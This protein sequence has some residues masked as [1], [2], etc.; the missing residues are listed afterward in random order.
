MLP[1]LLVGEIV[2][3][4]RGLGSCCAAAAAV[5]VASSFCRPGRILLAAFFCCSAEAQDMLLEILV[6]RFARCC[7]A[8][9]ITSLPERW[10]PGKCLPE[11]VM[12]LHC[13]NGLKALP[14]KWPMQPT[15]QFLIKMAAMHQVTC[16]SRLANMS[17]QQSKAERGLTEWA[18]L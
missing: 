8:S 18:T 13:G 9:C 14:W 15:A 17:I 6:C 3:P 11:G 16:P 1:L 2:V 12:Q 4:Q 5:V 10:C 7:S